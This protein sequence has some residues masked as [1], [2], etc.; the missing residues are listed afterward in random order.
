MKIIATEEHFTTK[1]H[2]DAVRSVIEEKYSEAAATRDEEHLK[3][4]ANWAISSDHGEA[5]DNQSLLGRLL[6]VGEGRLRQ[7]DEAGVDMQVLTPSLV[8][9]CT[10]WANPAASLKMERLTNERVAEVVASKPDRFIGLGGVPLQSPELAIREL[11][12]CVKELG[13]KGVQVSNPVRDMELGDPRLRP[14]WG[15]PP[16]L[17][18]TKKKPMIEAAMPITA[19]T[20]GR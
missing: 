18:P 19:T 11:E 15:S 17:V 13:L 16:S 5:P 2:A 4:E 1:E 10:Y 3:I 20:S 14:F 7:M 8:H 9:Q 6:D 12:R